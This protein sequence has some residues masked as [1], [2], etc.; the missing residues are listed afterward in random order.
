M[1][2]GNMGKVMKQV[3]KMQSQL[4]K[5][6]EELA[7]RTVEASS[8]GGVVR[9]VVN[10]KQEVVSLYISPEAVDP[11][12]IEMLQDLIVAAVNEALRRS[13]EMAAN[14]MAKITGQFKLPGLF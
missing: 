3:Q 11:D 7:Q 13:Q 2:I 4:A 14:E 1:G 5:I 9:A 10:G 6:Q 8:G 12:D